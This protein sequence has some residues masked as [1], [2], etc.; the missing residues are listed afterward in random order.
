M[1]GDLGSNPIA[2]T[3]DHVAFG[4]PLNLSKPGSTSAKGMQQYHSVFMKIK[5][6]NCEESA[7]T[8]WALCACLDLLAL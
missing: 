7:V 3:Y 1:S 2:T 5:F 6:N 4:E 8:L